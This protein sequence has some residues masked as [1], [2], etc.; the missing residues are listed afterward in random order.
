[1]TLQLLRAHE[2]T[3][4]GSPLAQER[5][6]LAV[7][8]LVAAGSL[9]EAEGRADAFAARYPRGLL[10]ESVEKAVGKKP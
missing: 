3:Y 9:R 1:V 10:R 6:A 4:P 7:K 2:R 5:D 8:A